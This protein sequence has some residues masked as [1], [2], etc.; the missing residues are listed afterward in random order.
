MSKSPPPGEEGQV[1]VEVIPTR[2]TSNI[3]VC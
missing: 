2:L 3:E 1:I